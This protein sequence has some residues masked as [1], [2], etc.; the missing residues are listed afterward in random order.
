MLG[1]IPIHWLVQILLDFPYRNKKWQ[2][3]LECYLCFELIQLVNMYS[4]EFPLEQLI[5]YI[6]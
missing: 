4:L 3:I 2:F 1:Q 5:Q 6:F